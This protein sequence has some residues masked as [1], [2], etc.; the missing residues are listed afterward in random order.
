[1]TALEGSRAVFFCGGFV[2]ARKICSGPAPGFVGVDQV[3]AVIPEEAPS[4]DAVELVVSLGD[5][6]SKPVTIGIAP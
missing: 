3:N 2:H 6:S 5:N 1:M 4:G